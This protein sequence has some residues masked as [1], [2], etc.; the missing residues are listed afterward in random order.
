MNALLQIGLLTLAAANGDVTLEVRLEPP[1]TPYHEQTRYSIVVERPEELK[2]K[3]PDMLNQFGG[4]S[5]YGLPDYHRERL[6]NGRVRITETYVLDPVFIGDYAIKPLEITWGEG[7]RLEV[8]SP[9]LRVRDLTE[10]EEALA[11]EF[12]AALMEPEKVAPPFYTR[13]EFWAL[14]SVAVAGLVAGAVYWWKRQASGHVQTAPP[15]HPW[16]IAYERLRALDQRQLTKSGDWERYYVDLS[17][18]LRYYVEDR[19]QLHAPERTTPEFLEELRASGTLNQDQ[20]KFMAVFL[21][22]CD[23]VKF[24]RYEPTVQEMELRFTDVLHFVDETVPAPEP[25]EQEEAA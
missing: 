17:A 13:W 8:P 19:F 15:K 21:R 14:A 1:V 11:M 5:I 20:E 3:L 18:I 7:Q 10:E 24:A 2:V 6:K 16:E 4:L 9:A 12:D 25:S 22:H 23:R